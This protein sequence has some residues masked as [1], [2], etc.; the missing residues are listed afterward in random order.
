MADS[1]SPRRQPPS[2]L[3][4]SPETV[5]P[6][7]PIKHSAQPAPSTSR[8]DTVSMPFVKRHVTRRLKNAKQEC[9]KELQ[10]VINFITTFFE[11]KLRETLDADQPQDD[12]DFRGRAR[13]VTTRRGSDTL[14]EPFSFQPADLNALAGSDADVEGSSDGGYEAEMEYFRYGAS[15]QRASLEESPAAQDSHKLTHGSPSLGLLTASTSSSPSSLRRQHTLPKDKQNLGNSP[16]SETTSPKKPPPVVTSPPI[17]WSNSGGSTSALSRRLSR[18]IHIPVRPAR[19]GQSSRSASRSRSPLPRPTHEE[20]KHRR[21]SRILIDDPVDPIMSTLYEII[22]LATDVIEMGVNH[23]IAQPKIC[24]QFVQRIQNIGRAWDDHPDWH[25]RNWYVQVLLSIASLSRVVEWWEAERQFWNFDEKKEEEQDEP[26]IFVM[27]PAYESTGGKEGE[28]PSAGTKDPYK[29]SA[30]EDN[31]LRITRPPSLGK[32]QRNEAPKESA[33]SST[34]TTPQRP[35]LADKEDSSRTPSRFMDTTESARVLATERL[36]LQAEKAQN[37]NVVMELSLDGDHILWINYAW[38]NV[39]GCVPSSYTTCWSYLRFL[40]PVLLFLVLV[41][42]LLSS[43]QYDDY[44]ERTLRNSK[45]PGYHICCLLPIGMSS[46]MPHSGCKKTIL[47]P[48][49]FGSSSRWNRTTTGIT[50][51]YAPWRAKACS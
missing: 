7:I 41:T 3:V 2:P 22:G 40:T 14:K 11:E 30:D 18:S 42:P 46:A 10:R 49:K 1:A 34:A 8:S 39:V 15:R 6:P 17:A 51:S 19:S 43:G 12:R 47:T 37:Q 28:T 29:L 5:L 24:E 26:L 23:L 45:E 50:Q 21:S 27:K 32:R 35:S 4:F 20:L 44:T 33:V 9:D 31:K 36:R 25:G 38:E 16:A 48:S 13:D